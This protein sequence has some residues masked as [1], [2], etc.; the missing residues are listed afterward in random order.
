MS[1]NSPYTFLEIYDSYAKNSME[2]RV[3]QT[4]VSVLCKL[5]SKSQNMQISLKLIC[6]LNDTELIVY[7]III[8]SYFTESSILPLVALS[9]LYIQRS[10]PIV[11]S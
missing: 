3:Y 10:P 8:D 5:A 6:R 1:L 11:D 2:Q 9:I 7:L 4:F